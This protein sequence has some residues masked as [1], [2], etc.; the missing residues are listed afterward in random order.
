MVKGTESVRQLKKVI[1]RWTGIPTLEQKLFFHGT[2]LQDDMTLSDLK[3]KEHFVIQVLRTSGKKNPADPDWHP[4]MGFW[5]LDHFGYLLGKVGK[6][7]FN[8]DEPHTE[9]NSVL[10]QPLIIANSIFVHPME[11]SY[12]VYRREYS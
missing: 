2:M 1:S 7:F 12:D 10:V 4:I 11:G 8:G 3:Q 9:V 6:M 5:E